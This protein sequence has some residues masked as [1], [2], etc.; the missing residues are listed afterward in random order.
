LKLERKVGDFA[1][2]AVGTYV[3]VGK[4]GVCTQVGISLTGVGPKN[5]RAGRAEDVLRGKVP[6][7]RPKR[8]VSWRLR[9]LLPQRAGSRNT[10][11]IWSGY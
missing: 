9:T 7:E 8:P 6:D 1:T 2:A 3:E 5:L 4:K 10:N 11:G